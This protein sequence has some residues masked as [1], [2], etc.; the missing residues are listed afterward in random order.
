[1]ELELDQGDALDV[2]ALDVLDAVDVEEVVLVIVGDEPF[3]LGGVHAAV[4]LGD[5]QRRHPEVGEDVARHA[6]DR[7][8]ARE[9]ERDHEDDDGDGTP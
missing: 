2:L 4:R 9:H 8:Q 6:L 3:H 7:E 5:V 1:V